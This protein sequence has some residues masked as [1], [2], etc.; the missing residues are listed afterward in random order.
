MLPEQDLV[1]LFIRQN[2]YI[3]LF[4]T[5]FRARANFVGNS[6]PRIRPWLKFIHTHTI[7]NCGEIP[8]TQKNQDIKS[9]KCKN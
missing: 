3:I 4:Y 6:A 8:N 9:L 5:K 7:L 2:K 1:L